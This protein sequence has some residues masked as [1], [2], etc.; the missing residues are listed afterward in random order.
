ML[1]IVI[2]GR[3]SEFDGQSWMR[4]LEIRKTGL[5]ESNLLVG[6]CKGEKYSVEYRVVDRSG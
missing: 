6:N 2:I 3:D 4:R 5:F 1:L